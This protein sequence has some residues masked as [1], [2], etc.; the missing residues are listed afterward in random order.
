MPSLGMVLVIDGS[1]TA[2]TATMPLALFVMRLSVL[3]ASSAPSRPILLGSSTM[4][5][6]VRNLCCVMPLTI[7]WMSS[8][9]AISPGAAPA[10]PVLFSS[11]AMFFLL[12]IC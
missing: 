3:A 1:E 10:D 8:I 5:A 11:A 12:I 7:S 6:S 4:P 2:A 9:R